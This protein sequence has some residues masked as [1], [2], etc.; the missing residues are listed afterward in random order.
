[1]LEAAKRDLIE[2]EGYGVGIVE[3]SHRSKQFDDVIESAKVV[4]NACSGW[5]TTNTSCSSTV[6]REPSSTLGR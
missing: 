4:S 3:C 2:H 6:E 5:M 1:M